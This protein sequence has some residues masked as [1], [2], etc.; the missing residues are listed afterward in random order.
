MEMKDVIKMFG[1]KANLA[2]AVGIT[3]QAINNWDDPLSP[4][5]SDRVVAA[6]VREGLDPTPLFNM[7][8]TEGA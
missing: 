1:S 3:A 2:R 8:D 6:C 4:T 7:P 5:A